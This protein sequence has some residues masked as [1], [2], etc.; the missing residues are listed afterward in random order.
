[1]TNPGSP[2]LNDTN[3]S[4]RSHYSSQGYTDVNN[5]NYEKQPI[6]LR[7]YESSKQRCERI[8]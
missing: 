8:S 6:Y 7:T 4:I 2:R 1:M 3:Y 5:N